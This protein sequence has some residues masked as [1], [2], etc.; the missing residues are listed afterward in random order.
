M[1]KP[2]I[3]LIVLFCFSEGILYAQEKDIAQIPP[4]NA[5]QDYLSAAKGYAALFSGKIE[6]PFDSRRF[7]N[8]AFFET[9]QYVKGVLCYNQ[10]IYPDIFMRLDL[11]RDELTVVFSPS[12]PRVVLEKDKFNYAVFNGSTLIVS[13][14]ASDT[15]WQYMLLIDDGRYPFVKKYRVT[16]R[17][18]LSNTD[19][20]RHFRFQEQYFIYIDE[21]AYPVKNKNS[22]L[23]LFP[24]R[25]KE[26]NEYARQHKL[27][28]KAQ[29][30][31]SVVELVNYYESLHK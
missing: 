12:S 17:E 27:N 5:I 14:Y 4:T 1:P 11:Y 19:V 7:V 6:T 29:F 16:V 24:D 15:G 28:F 13:R 20:K 23:K 3:L 8:H 18:E 21:T 10:V 2:I 9:E 22:L 25:K 26:L 31:Q 30:E